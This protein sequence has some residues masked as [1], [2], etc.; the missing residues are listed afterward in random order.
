MMTFSNNNFIIF[1]II[2]SK[3]F[4][5]IFLINFPRLADPHTLLMN[6]FIP[7]L[8]VKT[9]METRKAKID[10]PEPEFSY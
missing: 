3:H 7:D 2:Y 4:L 1:R 5:F 8:T 9:K 6:N 10:E